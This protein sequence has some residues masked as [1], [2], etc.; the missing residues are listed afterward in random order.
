[1]AVLASGLRRAAEHAEHISDFPA[2]ERMVF[3]F[4]VTMP[5]GV[6]VIA[7]R[8]LD[9]DVATIVGTA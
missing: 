1:M 9:F 2:D 6:P 8:T 4:V 3:N 7:G 5:A